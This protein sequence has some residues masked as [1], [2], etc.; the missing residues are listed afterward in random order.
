M[1]VWYVKSASLETHEEAEYEAWRGQ[2]QFGKGTGLR[3]AWEGAWESM[4]GGRREL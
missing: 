2:R 3:A 4:E 1:S